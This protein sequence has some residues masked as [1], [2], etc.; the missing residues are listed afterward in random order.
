MIDFRYHIVSLVAVFLALAVGVV[1]GAGPL[2]GS[3]GDQ[4]TVQI[5]QL[6][7]EKEELRIELEQERADNAELEA[8]IDASSDELLAGALTDVDV[9]VV[10]M[11]G[12]DGGQVEATLERIAQAGGDVVGRVSLSPRWT[13][14]SEQALRDEVAA[15]VADM[16]LIAPADDAPPEQVLGQALGQALAEADPLSTD[17]FTSTAQDMYAALLDAELV[18]EINT[19]SSP[20]DAVL[21]VAPAPEEPADADEAA[22]VLA[23]QVD[24]VTGLAGR[25]A[26]VAGVDAAPT[27]LVDAVR[28][29]PEAAAAVSTVDSLDQA[30]G[31]V[32]VP[33]ALGAVAAGAPVGH[34]GL[35]EGATEVLPTVPEAPTTEP[36]GDADADGDAGGAQEQSTDAADAANE[37]ETS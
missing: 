26:V 35:S 23:I 33:R 29:D 11:D 22:A 9:I 5:E 17:S 1:L 32:I 37:E 12:V 13:D 36:S 24:T 15:S 7:G 25:N 14:A 19:P 3:I 30:S 20:A 2:Q 16:M 21:V 10:E 28:A 4:L 27:D 18:T 8:F 31:Q 6:R 34:Y